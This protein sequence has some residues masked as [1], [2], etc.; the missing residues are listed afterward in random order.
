[1]PAVHR[2]IRMTNLYLVTPGMIVVLAAGI[3]LMVKG[4]WGNQS[5]I[6]VGF[7]A[8][9][10]LFGLVHGYFTRARARRSS[11]RSE[12]SPPAAS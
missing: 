10:V 8:I 5:W 9:I 4:D 12:T 1:M 11:S 2:A 7:I 6:T 3:Y